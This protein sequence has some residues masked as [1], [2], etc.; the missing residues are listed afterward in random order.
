MNEA[1]VWL[2]IFTAVLAA[3][4]TTCP[5]KDYSPETLTLK[6]REFAKD[7]AKIADAAMKEFQQRF[8]T[9][10]GPYR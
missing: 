3:R 6:M 8:S 9:S 5:T 7:S 10:G 1:D 4:S 2:H